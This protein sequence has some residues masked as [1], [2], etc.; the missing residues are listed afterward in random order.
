M[1][2]KIWTL[3]K[4]YILVKNSIGNYLGN[5]NNTKHYD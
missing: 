5:S 4:M 2:D 1:P 3:D